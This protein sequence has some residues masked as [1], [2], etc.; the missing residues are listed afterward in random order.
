MKKRFCFLA[1]SFLILLTIFP[2]PGLTT[3]RGINI[4]SRQGQSLYLYKDYHALVVGISNYEKWPDLPN[5][6]KDAR[7]VATNLEQFGFEV[8]LVLNPSSRE[9][10]SAL[11]EVVYGIGNQKKRALL[12]YFAGHGETLEL[13]DGTELGYIIP[14]DCPLKMKD[15][16][17]FDDKAVSMKEMEILALKVKS[18][19]LLMVFDSCFSGSIFNLVRAAPV[20]ISE[21]SA[22]PV[23]QFIT[24]GGA[25][26]QVPDQSV[27][28]VVFLN[29]IAGDADLNGDAYVTGSELGMHL[30]E[31][32]VNYSRGGQHPQYGKIN[33]PKL[34]RGDFI[35]VPLPTRGKEVTEETDSK[36]A[37]ERMA[38]EEELNRLRAE[39][40]KTSRTVREL[41]A[42]EAEEKRL[43]Y[44]PKTTKSVYEE[45]RN[46]RGPLVIDDFED[47]DL[48]SKSFNDK[49]RYSKKGRASLTLSVDTTQG[50]NGTNSSMKIEYK[51]NERSATAT[52]IGGKKAR[53]I[54]QVENDRSWAYDLSRF[55][56]ITFYLKG[57]K[58]KSFFSRPNKLFVNIGCYG[59]RIKASYGKFAEYHNRTEVIPDTAW[60]KVEIPF[61]DLV[62]STRTRLR[63]TNYPD[64]P[65]L[66][67]VLFIYFVF[68]SFPSHDGYPGSNTVWIDEITLE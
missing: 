59:A 63:A 24:A 40:E 25:G 55:D 31:K 9:M 62:V 61:D 3:T 5:A 42:R 20:D 64:N 22:M 67:N 68:S 19:H 48:W 30:Q 2:T 12:I 23:R 58:S 21:K 11:T 49:W 1:L 29:G 41:Q 39:M 51:L 28:K 18:K 57:E 38:L 35:F 66:H 53:R 14:S 7:E 34:D 65:N 60:K 54:K 45:L 8:K 17:G 44:A 46:G 6:V 13:A 26:E 4:T 47:K 56:K 33:N 27:F 36:E 32:V 43:A 15:P 16:M 52:A 37:A 50:A 10:K